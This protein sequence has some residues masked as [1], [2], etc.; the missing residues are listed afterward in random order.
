LKEYH[1]CIV[2]EILVR[3]DHLAKLDLRVTL[4]KM[5]KTARMV[6]QEAKAS[7]VHKA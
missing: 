2:R 1:I 5:E 7:R 4:V 6:N 3:L